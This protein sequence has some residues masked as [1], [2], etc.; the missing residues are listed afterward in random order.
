MTRSRIY[1]VLAALLAA[2]GIWQVGEAGYM[3]AKALLAQHLLETSWAETVATG[4]VGETMAVGG[5]GADR[6]PCG[7]QPWT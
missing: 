1:L 4:K 5:H 7:C 3:H 6:P 2:F